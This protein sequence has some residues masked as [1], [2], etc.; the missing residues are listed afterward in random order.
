[1]VL[2]RRAHCNQLFLKKIKVKGGLYNETLLG[3]IVPALYIFSGSLCSVR[4]ITGIVT[5][6]E[7]KEP[8]IGASIVLEGTALGSATDIDGR[9]VIVNVPR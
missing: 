9:F 1:M 4:K 6:R 2:R 5:D 7:S 3:Y 8:L